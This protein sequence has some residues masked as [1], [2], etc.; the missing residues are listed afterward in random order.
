MSRKQNKEFARKPTGG[1]FIYGWKPDTEITKKRKDKVTVK[2]E[3][4]DAKA[5]S[6]GT[7]NV[8]TFVYDSIN[9]NGVLSRIAYVACDYVE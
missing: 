1:R 2:L 9:T 5:G 3:G 4:C 6:Q 8:V 7:D